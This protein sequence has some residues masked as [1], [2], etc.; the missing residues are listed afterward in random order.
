[1]NKKLFKSKQNIWDRE[2]FLSKQPKYWKSQAVQLYSFAGL[3]ERNWNSFNNEEYVEGGI[4]EQFFSAPKFIRMIWGYAIENLMKGLLLKR[5][6]ED[7]YIK[8]N[9]ISWGKNGHN[10]I[11]LKGELKYNPVFDFP[12]DWYKLRDK[13]LIEID[14]YLEIWSIS[15]T[16]YGKYPFPSG[17]N[18]VLDEYSSGTR[19]ELFKRVIKGE[20][21]LI[22]SD[23][24]GSD[25]SIFEKKIFECIYQDLSNNIGDN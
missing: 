16:W 3:L 9:K 25:I 14:F 8:N 4:H 18:G 6:I 23:I 15:A 19:E 21:K 13:Y 20:R 5:D 2:L 10:L 22:I 17:M 1:M 11:W 7:K 12:E 24:I